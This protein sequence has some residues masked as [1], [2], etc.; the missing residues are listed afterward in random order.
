MGDT[1]DF[2]P[3]QPAYDFDEA[4]AI[5]GSSNSVKKALRLALAFGSDDGD[6]HKMWVIDQMV[7]ALAGDNYDKLI[8]SKRNGEDGPETYEWDTGIAP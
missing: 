3:Q 7:R 2:H 5:V 6:H 4:I 8:A 1:F